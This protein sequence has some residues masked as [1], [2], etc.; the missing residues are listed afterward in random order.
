VQFLT[1]S[2][3]DVGVSLNVIM[4]ASAI[5]VAST[6]SNVASLGTLFMLSTGRRANLQ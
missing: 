4:H 6:L 5:M 3:A 1:Y 2:L